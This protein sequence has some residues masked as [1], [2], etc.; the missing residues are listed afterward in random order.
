[1]RVRSFGTRWQVVACLTAASLGGSCGEPATA[2]V[3]A[4]GERL[5]LSRPWI[6]AAPASVGIDAFALAAAADSL[7]L[8]DRF[9]SFLVCRHGRLVFEGYYGGAGAATLFDVRSVT[10]SVTALL[11]GIAIDEG[12]L[13]GVDISIAGELAPR[14]EL[15]RSDSAVTIRDLLTMT[16]GF[17]WE[18]ERDWLPWLQV[19]DPVQD[20]LD[21]AHSDPPGQRF[22]Y[23]GAAVHVLS[24]ALARATGAELRGYAVD[25]LLH[26]IGASRSDWLRLADG[27]VNGAAGLSVTSRE[28]LKLGQLLLQDGWSGSRSVVPASWVRAATTRRIVSMSDYDG[29][30]GLS[31]GYLW[32]TADGPVRAFFGWGFGGQFVFVAPSLDVVLVTTT[33]WHDMSFPAG[34]ASAERILGLLVRRALPAI[35]SGP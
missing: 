6:T 9:R 11:V 30:Q 34:D 22:N 2:P 10:K 20:L 29:L 21:R 3:P 4:P 18:E 7:A 24:V 26:P 27:R 32:W 19:A 8:D 28:L 31:Y 17:R 5:D 35:A 23:D 14:Y 12:R 15:D 13:P 25:R 16:S 33:E 1:M